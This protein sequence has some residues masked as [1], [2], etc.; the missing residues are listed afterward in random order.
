M[1]KRMKMNLLAV[2]AMPLFLAAVSFATLGGCTCNGGASRPLHAMGPVE[3]VDNVV[4]DPANSGP[5]QFPLTVTTKRNFYPTS[6][7]I[8][9]LLSDSQHLTI[10]VT[11]TSVQLD[12]NKQKK[13]S[14]AT[15]G[16]HQGN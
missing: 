15:S 8:L 1:V 12:A 14:A 11:G 16:P 5:H 9:P 13:I 4:A 10:V 7:R 3:P 6:A 2:R